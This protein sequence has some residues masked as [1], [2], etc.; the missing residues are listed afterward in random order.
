MTIDELNGFVNEFNKTK[1]SVGA[2]LTISRKYNISIEELGEPIETK[3]EF[4]W[5]LDGLG[6]LFQCKDCN[7]MEFVEIGK[8]R[9]HC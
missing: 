4:I 5:T 8:N 6:E 1:K 9:I 2:L 3:N 7:S